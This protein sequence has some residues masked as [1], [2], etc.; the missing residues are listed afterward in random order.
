MGQLLIIMLENKF[1]FKPYNSKYKIY[2]KKEQ[3]QLQDTLGKNASIE[4]IGSTYISKLGGKGIVDVVVGMNNKNLEKY[5]IP[6]EK[7]NYVYRKCASKPGRIFFRKDY[8]FKGKV[9][10]VHIHLVKYKSHEWNELILFREFLKNHPSNAKEYGALKKKAVHQSKGNGLI[11]KN[12]KGTYI[13]KILTK[14]L[15]KI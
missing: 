4:H 1:S 15:K 11:Y 14:I 13:N 9:R 3:K 8:L 5:I 6:L 10:R 7:S 2:F 12:I